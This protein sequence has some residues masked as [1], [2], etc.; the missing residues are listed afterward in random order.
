[1]SHNFNLSRLPFN[2]KTP[3]GYLAAALIQSATITFA[4]ELFIIILVK[5]IGLCLFV[6]DFA[7]D[8]EQDL[9]RFNSDLIE[10]ND[11]RF[12]TFK[13]IDM[14]TKLIHIILFQSEAVV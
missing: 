14:K 5:T 11:E 8:L 9:H 2:W 13:R 12:S 10:R 7:L 6:T 1:M 4:T 3:I